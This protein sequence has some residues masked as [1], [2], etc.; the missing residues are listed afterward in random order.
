VKGGCFAATVNSST[1]AL[2]MSAASA[3]TGYPVSAPLRDRTSTCKATALRHPAGL[4]IQQAP[5]TGMQAN[6]CTAHLRRN[7]VRVLVQIQQLAI[8]HAFTCSQQ[9]SRL[10]GWSSTC[11]NKICQRASRHAAIWHTCCKLHRRREVDQ[12]H[13][14]RALPIFCFGGIDIQRVCCDCAVCDATR[15]QALQRCEQAMYGLHGRT[16]IR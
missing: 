15:M 1:P 11:V 6:A 8:Q 3:V 10:L 13:I 5:T 9:Q 7:G 12:L 4:Q 16:N 2:H 14:V